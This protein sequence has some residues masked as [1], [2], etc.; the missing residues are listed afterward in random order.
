MVGAFAPLDAGLQTVLFLV[1]GQMF[2]E[3]YEIP[4]VS[5]YEWDLL[6]KTLTSLDE[7]SGVDSF[8][9]QTQIQDCF[10][11]CMEV[12]NS[13]FDLAPQFFLLL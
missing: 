3:Y 12:D 11:I 2:G 10:S 9:G 5:E 8:A 7:L 1:E 6:H 13:L 4:I